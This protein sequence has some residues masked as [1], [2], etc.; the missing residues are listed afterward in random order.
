[1]S[2][3]MSIHSVGH[4]DENGFLQSTMFRKSLYSIHA[5]LKFV[6]RS[7]LGYNSFVQNSSGIIYCLLFYYLFA[8]TLI[9][10]R[11]KVLALTTSATAMLKIIKY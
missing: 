11:I 2:D 6:N 8:A 10:P 7:S 3:L 9:P 4:C 1:M 5:D